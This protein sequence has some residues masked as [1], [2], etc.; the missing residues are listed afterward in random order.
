MKRALPGLHQYNME[1]TGVRGEG[2]ACRR[3]SIDSGWESSGDI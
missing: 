2:T 3:N 1:G